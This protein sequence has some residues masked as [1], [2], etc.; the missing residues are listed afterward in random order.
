MDGAATYTRQGLISVLM[1]LMDEFHPTLIATQDYVG[2]FG[3]GD[4]PDHHATAYFTR[5]AQSLYAIPH[6]FVGYQDYATSDLPA[7]V[8][9][10]DLS[11]KSAAF[12]TYA[13]YDP[14]VCQTPSACANGGY[15]A[16]LQRQYTVSAQQGNK[17]GRRRG[18]RRLGRLGRHGAAR[19]IGEQRPGRRRARLRVEADGRPRRDAVLGDVRAADVHRSGRTRHADV[20]PDRLRRP[21]HPAAPTR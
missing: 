10:T 14:E 7:N 17:A 8:S 12:Y 16:W 15:A 3:D 9:G 20:L 11:D 21:G 2:V 1:A 19:R 18:P 13:P 5:Q 4:H 6:T